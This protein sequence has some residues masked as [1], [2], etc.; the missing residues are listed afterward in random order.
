MSEDK[1]MAI[2]GALWKE[3]LRSPFTTLRWI[4]GSPYLADALTKPCYL[5]RVLRSAMWSFVQ[6][7]VAAAC[8]KR[9]QAQGSVRKA[10]QSAL[11]E[12]AKR[13]ARERRATEM[14]ELLVAGRATL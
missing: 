13:Q 5:Y 2:E 9:K 7:P 11:K 6:G 10:D 1:R 12:D 14:A 4:D 8:Q 3:T